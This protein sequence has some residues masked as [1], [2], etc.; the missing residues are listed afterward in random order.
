MSLTIKFIGGRAL[1]K[2]LNLRKQGNEDDRVLAVDIKVSGEADASILNDLLGASVGDDLSGMF[3]SA[4]GDTKNDP[5][6]LRSYVLGEIAIDGEWPRRLLNLG[7]H[8][9]IGDL[10]KVTFTPR[11]GHRLDLVGSISVEN[12]PK[13]LLEYLLKNLQE[14]FICSIEDAEQ[15]LHFGT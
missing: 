15:Q 2:H 5:A 3:W 11:P 7:K 6:S 1:L 4:G 10:K 12:P 13:E 8:T 9:V 14:H